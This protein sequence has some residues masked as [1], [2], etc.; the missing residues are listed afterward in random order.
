M[1][2]TDSHSPQ[3]TPTEDLI[4]QMNV[5]RAIPLHK[6][7]QKQNRMNA[8][9]TAHQFDPSETCFEI[10]DKKNCQI[11]QTCIQKSERHRFDKS[12]YAHLPK[13]GVLPRDEPPLAV[14]D[15]SIA[16]KSVFKSLNRFL[17][18]SFFI[19]AVLISSAMALVALIDPL[20]TKETG[21]KDTNTA[22]IDV[23]M[24]DTNSM[25]VLPINHVKVT[26]AFAQNLSL[27]NT[28]TSTA[29]SAKQPLSQE[30]E[31]T[32]H[33]EIIESKTPT[34]PISQENRRLPENQGSGID[35]SPKSASSIPEIPKPLTQADSPSK[36]NMSHT[37]EAKNIPVIN[38]KSNPASARSTEFT[39]VKPASKNNIAPLKEETKVN[40]PPREAAKKANKISDNLN[41]SKKTS[42]AKT[43]N[44]PATPVSSGAQ[45][46]HNHSLESNFAKQNTNSSTPSVQNAK[47]IKRPYPNYPQR[48]AALNQE[49]SVTVKFDVNNNGKVINIRII[50][51]NPNNIF[52]KE[53]KRALRDWVYE[54]IPTQDIMVTFEFKMSGINLN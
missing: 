20:L 26:S 38:Q 7:S 50:S 48:A 37:Q 13:L 5:I 11:S 28:E 17:F 44:T 52:D 9:D 6:N 51:S 3:N 54:R 15:N 18:T 40:Q 25:A 47:P 30:I 16:T 21:N 1:A 24:I 10:C 41:T 39:E 12:D 23:V 8:L 46:E 42:T 49:G 36:S 4:L 27:K 33:L 45:A 43:T 29:I 2:N 35:S 19:H 14:E 53:V 22:L 34:Q 32:N 31:S